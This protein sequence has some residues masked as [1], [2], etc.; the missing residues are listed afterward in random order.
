METSHPPCVTSF[1]KTPPPPSCCGLQDCDDRPRKAEQ[2]WMEQDQS[3]R[4]QESSTHPNQG[5]DFLKLGRKQEDVD[6]TQP[7][8]GFQRE[9]VNKQEVKSSSRGQNLH[10]DS[11]EDQT[12]ADQDRVHKRHL[13]KVQALREQMEEL[14][15]RFT[16]RQSEWSAVRFHLGLL[17]R[18][19]SELREKLKVRPK[20]C[21]RAAQTHA[22]DHQQT[23]TTQC[24]GEQK[25][26]TVTFLN[27]DI[28]HILENGKVVYYYAESQTTQTTH[29]SGL[30][31]LRFPNE[32]IEKR[33]PGGKRE[34]L[35]PDQTI[36]YVEPDG[37]E[38][39]IFPDGTIVHLSQSGEKIIDF[40]SGQKV[41][42]TSQ[43]K[44]REYPDG[45][46]KTVYPN[47]R[48]ETKY[49]SGRTR[50]RHK[51]GA[52]KNSERETEGHVRV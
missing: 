2:R 12:E 34:I 30:E 43:Y 25:T 14:Q 42:H 48:Q 11:T 18:E 52:Q 37:S 40:P 5:V 9:T 4:H 49:A 32:Q 13:S 29:P 51:S 39:T 1:P 26:R 15:Q 20:S 22:V 27:G 19:N 24:S 8:W 35:F 38:E 44:R 36:T 41:T 31:V 3:L 7:S 28:K 16:D 47:G 46:V 50:I 21:P 33:H 6:E 10:R 17:M 45:R 23:Q